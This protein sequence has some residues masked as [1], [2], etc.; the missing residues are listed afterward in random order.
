MLTSKNSAKLKQCY[1]FHAEFLG[2]I[3]VNKRT[4]LL[5]TY[6]LISACF[7]PVIKYYQG[8]IEPP[9]AARGHVT[10]YTAKF[11][12]HIKIVLTT[13]APRASTRYTGTV[14]R[15]SAVVTL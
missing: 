3:L 11:K 1:Y 5:S 9:K 14:R 2:N 8:L 10:L 6:F 13:T 4:C 7:L 12:T 15:D